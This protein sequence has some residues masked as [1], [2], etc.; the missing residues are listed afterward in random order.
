M[1]I[2]TRLI[3]VFVLCLI[4]GIGFADGTSA[5]AS[6]ATVV[7]A[8]DPSA[9]KL[10]KKERLR[11]KAEADVLFSSGNYS[12]ALG[13]YGLL[14]KYKWKKDDHLL[15]LYN[16]AVSYRNQ[17]EYDKAIEF[18]LHCTELDPR[19]ARPHLKLAMIYETIH[20]YGEA[21]K[22]YKRT[23]ELG[24]EKFEC[25][26]GLGRIYQGLGLNG[27][28]VEHYRQ[29]LLIRST[30]EIYRQLSRCYETLNN[31]ELAASMLKQVISQEG[32]AASVSDY[33]QLSFL[34]S[35]QQK[36]EDALGTIST[37]INKWPDNRELKFHLITIHFKKGDIKQARALVGA[38]IEMEPE[39]ALA[40]FLMGLIAYFE[41]SPG[42]LKTVKQEMER[43]AAIAKTPMLK[44]YSEIFVK[45]LSGE[46]EATGKR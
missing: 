13:K 3:A 17:G 27:Q 8:T 35:I 9:K 37:A 44:E 45:H 19:D 21:T 40:H 4:T 7:S 22:S 2:K 11:L 34:Y 15:M 25:Y 33:L 10:S 5:T 41:K 14:L 46:T 29:A 24:K 30:N 38:M 26:S 23:L 1:A 43:A 16:T 12:S 36:Y 32:E 6:P 28:A 31:R 42:N 18:L 39:D 20:L